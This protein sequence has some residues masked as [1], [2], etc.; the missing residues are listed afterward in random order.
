MELRA[1]HSDAHSMPKIGRRQI[2]QFLSTGRARCGAS[3]LIMQMDP[4]MCPHC[5]LI[6][7]SGLVPVKKFSRH[8][9][10]LFSFFRQST[11]GM[12][13]FERSPS[14]R[15][16]C[17]NSC[18][19]SCRCLISV[20]AEQSRDDS[21]T[22]LAGPLVLGKMKG[23]L[24]IRITSVVNVADCDAA[25]AGA[26]TACSR[27]V[28]RVIFSDGG[29]DVLGDGAESAARGVP[30]CDCKVGAFVSFTR[31]I[32]DVIP[33]GSLN[34][35]CPAAD[36]A[37]PGELSDEGLKVNAAPSGSVSGERVAKIDGP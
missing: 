16:F 29:A 6:G 12:V 33:V 1:F 18:I 25:V 5:N 14:R 13:K 8:T 19:W 10:H 36:P 17:F 37:L 9:W 27:R 31:G 35:G 24:T 30:G 2:G 20:D 4:Q 7:S 22:P 28:L 23:V 15:V 26:V 21:V 34:T 32:E 3:H 11:S